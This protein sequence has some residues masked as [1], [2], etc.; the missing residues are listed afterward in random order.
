ML[1]CLMVAF[2]SLYLTSKQ[3]IILLLPGA[4]LLPGSRLCSVQ[5]DYYLER[6]IEKSARYELNFYR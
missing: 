2:S 6:K 4:A 1:F 3:Q 5:S